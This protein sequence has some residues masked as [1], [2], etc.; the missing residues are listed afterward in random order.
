MKLDPQVIATMFRKKHGFME[1]TLNGAPHLAAYEVFPDWN[2][3]IVQT[4]SAKEMFE[5]RTEYLKQG[6]FA[7]PRN[8]VYLCGRIEPF[9][10]EAGRP[11][12][13]YPGMR[14]R[15]PKREI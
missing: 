9:R 11:Y 5:K 6:V 14:S 8:P 3:L 15:C 2:W 12:Q 7:R 10:T 13:D 4:V 1:F